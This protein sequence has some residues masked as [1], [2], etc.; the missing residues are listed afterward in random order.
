MAKHYFLCDEVAELLC[1]KFV[2]IIG[3]S[4]NV[5]LVSFNVLFNDGHVHILENLTS[6][7]VH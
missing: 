6:I 1:N 4:G 5:Y 3:D 2:V 7:P